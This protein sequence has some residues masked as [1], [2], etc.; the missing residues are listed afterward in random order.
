MSDAS[1]EWEGGSPWL[2]LLGLLVFLASALLFVVDFARGIDVLRSLVA[3][4]VGAALLI[5]WAAH[6][7]LHDPNSEVA[8][9]GGAAGTALLLYALYLLGA[10]IVI[11]V[12][13]F[14]HDRQVLGL[15]YVAVAFLAATVGFVI[16]PREAVLA[17][18]EETTAGDSDDENTDEDPEDTAV[19]AAEEGDDT[20]DDGEDAD[21]DGSTDEDA[22]MATDNDPNGD[23][24]TDDTGDT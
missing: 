9:A 16:F 1:A 8:T 4:T 5:T 10:G 14:F 21:G 3:N 18:D 15:L 17:D 13:G 11:A 20:A 7:T 23:D 22:D 19:S 6:D 12:T 2:F 24:A